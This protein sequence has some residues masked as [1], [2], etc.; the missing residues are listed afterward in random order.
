[1]KLFLSALLCSFSFSILH[2]AGIEGRSE[3]VVKA[4]EDQLKKKAKEITDDDLAKVIELKLPHIHIPKFKDN[5]FDGLKNMKKL[6]FFSLL[7]N[8][9][10][11]E[12]PIAIGNEVFAGLSNLEELQMNEQLGLLPDEVFSGLTSLKI[13]DL[14]TASLNRLP[15]TM[16]TLPSIEK[17]IFNGRGMSPEDYELLKKTY[18]NKLIE[19]K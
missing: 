14:T 19:K 8:R 6:H 5:D 12:D 11:P 13:L 10:R 4:L 7:H 15:K 18:G 17:I 9:G 1:M 2:A 16:L 3:P